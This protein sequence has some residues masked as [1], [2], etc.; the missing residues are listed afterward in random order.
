MKHVYSLT[1]QKY[2]RYMDPKIILSTVPTGLG[3]IRVTKALAKGLP[4]GVKPLILGITDETISMIYRIISTH[5]VL[6]KLFEFIQT[7]PIVEKLITNLLIY[8]QTSNTKKTESLLRELIQDNHEQR[9]I[10]V[11]THAFIAQKIQKIIDQKL[12]PNPITHAVVITDDSPQ[13]FWMVNSNILFAPS[14]HTKNALLKLYSADRRSPPKI[15]VTPYPINPE[16]CQKL[17]AEVLYNKIEQLHP[18]NPQPA[19]I[20]LPVSGAAVHLDYYKIVIEE[21]LAHTDIDD[22]REFTFSIVTREGNYTK[23]FIDYFRE[24]S[25]ITFHIGANDEQT[26]DL[27]DQLY[28][29]LNPPALEITKPS[30]QCF[31]ALTHPDTYGGPLLLLTEPVG[32]Q[33]Y[34]NL[35]FLQR[36]GFL[37]TPDEHELLIES[38][39]TNNLNTLNQFKDNARTWRCLNLPLNPHKAAIFIQLCFNSGIF[40]AMQNYKPYIENQELSP[41]GVLKIWEKL[42]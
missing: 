20:C 28:H 6:R 27:Y 21:L 12:L 38:L 35:N 23:S 16:F 17:P 4:T 3:H 42:N 39:L 19:R 26:V 1:F 10:V 30:E 36:H 7:N 24:N 13:R 11:S 5:W 41:N 8:I 31:K 2:A 33:E 22:R 40:M 34:D 14:A 18:E 37:P 25:E 29:Q 32:R 15:E 9:V